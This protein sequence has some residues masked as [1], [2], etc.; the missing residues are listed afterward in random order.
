MGKKIPEERLL[1]LQQH[2]DLLLSRNP[3]RI[4]MIQTFA[5]LYAVSISTVYRC[6]REKRTPKSLRRSDAELPGFC[7]VQRWS[8]IAKSLLP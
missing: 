4:K 8:C 6:L 1:E 3:D 2:L 5:D 7:K